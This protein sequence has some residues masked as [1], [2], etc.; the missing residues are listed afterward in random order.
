M[1]APHSDNSIAWDAD[2]DADDAASA[3]V[4]SERSDSASEDTESEPHTLEPIAA[5]LPKDC[6]CCWC[7]SSDMRSANDVGGDSGPG[8]ASAYAEISASCCC[9]SRKSSG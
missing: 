9:C 1:C 6:C 5:S 2:A 4:A 7:C 3:P 8:M